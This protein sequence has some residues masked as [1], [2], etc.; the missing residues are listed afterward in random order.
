MLYDFTVKLLALIEVST[1]IVM[2]DNL[3]LLSAFRITNACNYSYQQN[4][5]VIKTVDLAV[6]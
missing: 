5:Q 6:A 2:D 1:R 4:G 3:D